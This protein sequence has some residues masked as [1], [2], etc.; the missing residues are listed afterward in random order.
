MQ[1]QSIG[2]FLGRCRTLVSTVI[3]QTSHPPSHYLSETPAGGIAPR[4]RH[5]LGAWVLL[6]GSKFVLFRRSYALR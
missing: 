2:R 3:T 1:A 4:P 6:I 5:L